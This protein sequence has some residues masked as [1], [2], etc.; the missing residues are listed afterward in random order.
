LIGVAEKRAS[1]RDAVRSVVG[2]VVVRLRQ[3]EGTTKI[4][5]V[6]ATDA[7]L[8]DAEKLF[9]QPGPAQPAIGMHTGSSRLSY[10][11]SKAG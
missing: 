10:E 11:S 7:P 6:M 4:D 9:R 5:L 3:V 8:I 1:L 2:I